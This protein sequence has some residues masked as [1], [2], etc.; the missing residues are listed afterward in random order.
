MFQVFQSNNNR[1][2]PRGLIV[3]TM[4]CRTVVS[5]FELYPGYYVHVRKNELLILP[6]KG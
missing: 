6:A 3:K 2:C 5:E 1:E 4:D